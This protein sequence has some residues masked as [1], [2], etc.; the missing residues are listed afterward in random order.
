MSI[1]SRLAR[2]SSQSLRGSANPVDRL[3]VAAAGELAARRYL[4][5]RGYLLIE[6]NYRCRHGEIDL[7]MQDGET[8]V[9]VEVKARRSTSA[10]AP[11]EAVDTVKQRHLI[12]AGSDYL[13]QH[14]LSHRRFRF[15]VVAI[16]YGRSRWPSVTH[17]R[18]AIEEPARSQGDTS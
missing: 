1:L 14:R 15:D 12:A 7:V 9:F 10:G 17:Y 11:E 13:R 4:E 16:Q 6:P 8:I 3:G 5:R 18:D 2:R